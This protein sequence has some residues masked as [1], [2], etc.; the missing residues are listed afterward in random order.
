MS[1]SEM[2]SLRKTLDSVGPREHIAEPLSGPR[3]SR[4]KT[5]PFAGAEEFPRANGPG[6]GPV[7]R[8]L[9]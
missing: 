3:L 2:P 1:F 6:V 5:Y 8:V 9:T 4:G 7:R